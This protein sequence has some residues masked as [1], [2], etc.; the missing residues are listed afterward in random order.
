VW[1]AVASALWKL[2]RRR[3]DI[4]RPEL[5]RWL[6]DERRIPVAREALKHI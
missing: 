3:P 6:E 2:G 1:R 4:V 5:S